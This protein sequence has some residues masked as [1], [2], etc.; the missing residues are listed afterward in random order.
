MRV[1]QILN[2]VLYVVLLFGSIGWFFYCRNE[3]TMAIPTF[4]LGI[5]GA[6]FYIVLAI[7]MIIDP[8][9]PPSCGLQAWSS[10]LRLADMMTIFML[11]GFMIL[12]HRRNA[13]ISSVM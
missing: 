1:D 13:W 10:V 9:C 11:L 3:K 6:L 5:F 12:L 7:R 4:V 2:I 8:S